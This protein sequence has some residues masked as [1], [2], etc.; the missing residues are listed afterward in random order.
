MQKKWKDQTPFIM[1][2]LST[3][4]NGIE[5][6]TAKKI[7][8]TFKAFLDEKKLGFGTVLPNFRLAVTGLGTGPSMF[9]TSELLGKQEVLARIQA[10]LDNIQK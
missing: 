6:F 3:I 4:L 2:E 7:E 10:A 1:K 5:E 9:Q 8:V